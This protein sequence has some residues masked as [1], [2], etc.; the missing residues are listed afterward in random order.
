MSKVSEFHK[1]YHAHH[2]QR[3]S[4]HEEA[5]DA[6]E[7]GSSRHAFHKRSIARHETLRDYHAAEMGKATADE[8]NKSDLVPTNVSALTPD[9]P[10]VRAIPRYGQQTPERP[11]VPE[12]FAHL[13]QVED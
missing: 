7:K 9:K 6:E 11:A 13:A 3:I 2:D 1:L 12:Q 10:G 5:M 4:D 8:L